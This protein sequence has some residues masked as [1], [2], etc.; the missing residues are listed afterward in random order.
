MRGAHESL[1]AQQLLSLFGLNTVLDVLQMIQTIAVRAV[2][3]P[4][5]NDYRTGLL[6]SLFGGQLHVT[7]LIC[8][9]GLPYFTGKPVRLRLTGSAL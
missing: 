1:C 5:R 6:L 2:F 7:G 3:C 8:S 4:S 9:D